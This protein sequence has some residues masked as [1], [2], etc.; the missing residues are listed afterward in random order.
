MKNSSLR[1]FTSILSVFACFVCL[2][3]MKADPQVVP[4]PD[5]CYPGFTTAEGCR[6]LQSLT[7]G[8]GNTGVGWRS[9][10]SVGDGSFNTG[11]GAGALVLNTNDN[12]T[13]VGAVA[14]LLNTTGSDNTAVGTDALALNV[15]ASTNAAVG[16]FAAQNNDSSGNATAFF[17]TAIGGFALQA[18]VD[19]TENT[20]VGAGAIESGDGGNDNTA[21]GYVAGNHITGNS[22]TCLG[23]SAGSNL[24]GGESNIYIG[25]QVQAGSTDELEFIRIGS[26]TAFNFSYDTYIAGIFN[27]GVD[28]GTAQFVFADANGKIGTVPADAAG[29]K[30]ATPQAML[31]ESRNQQ[32]R[33]AELEGTVERQQ[34]GMEVL[35]TQLK[36]QAVQIQKVSAELEVNKPAPHVVANKQ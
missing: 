32:K 20:A 29:N 35:A 24:I 5:G 26:D 2:P 34:K 14:L 11:V 30:V 1:I 27:R 6:A 3:Q 33:I 22:N 28:L 10:F 23:H 9:L 19:G 12:N 31:N 13:A 4:T 16:T 7:T 21:V 8:S 17:N 18:N 25:A 15:S 36:E